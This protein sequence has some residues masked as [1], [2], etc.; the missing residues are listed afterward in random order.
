MTKLILELL[1]EYWYVNAVLAFV[2]IA[3]WKDKGLL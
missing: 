1:A 3:Y 2:L